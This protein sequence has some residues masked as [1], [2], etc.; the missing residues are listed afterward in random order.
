METLMNGATVVE[1]ALL[2]LLLALCIARML[3]CALFRLM[4]ATA[5]TASVTPHGA[6][7]VV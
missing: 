6:K 1:A 4:P 3:M 2:S 5:R 7:R